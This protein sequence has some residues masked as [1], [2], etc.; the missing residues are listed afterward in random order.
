V[1]QRDQH[2]HGVFPL[3]SERDVGADDDQRR[4]DRDQGALR[5]RLAEDR[6]DRVEVEAAGAV[7]LLQAVL[8]ALA[9]G[10]VS[11]SVEIWKPLPPGTSLPLRRWISASPKPWPDST[12]RTPSS[13]AVFTSAS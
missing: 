9:L 6:A 7:L 5:D 12:E 8:D 1:H 4:D 2:R 3:E 11:V 10:L 13:F